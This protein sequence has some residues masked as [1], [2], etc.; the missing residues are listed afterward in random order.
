[1]LQRVSYFTLFGR[2]G[3]IMNGNSVKSSTTAANGDKKV[4]IFDKDGTLLCMN[5]MLAPWMIQVA[6]RMEAATGL[7]IKDEIYKDMGFDVHTRKF[8]SGHV[9]EST[10]EVCINSLSD[11]LVKKGLSSEKARDVSIHSYDKDGSAALQE[12]Y[13]LLA[14]CTVSSLG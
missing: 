10:N 3:Q 8:G 9:L 5:A 14:M 11:L 13:C 1:M 6:E 2:V 4:A 12:N 7:S